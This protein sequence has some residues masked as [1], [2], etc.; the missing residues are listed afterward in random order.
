MVEF[1]SKFQGSDIKISRI[2]SIH[3]AKLLIFFNVLVSM[4]FQIHW[5]QIYFYLLNWDTEILT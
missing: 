5:K 4:K 3:F 2:N 1:L